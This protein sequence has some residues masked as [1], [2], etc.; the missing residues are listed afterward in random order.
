MTHRTLAASACCGLIAIGLAAS[1]ACSSRVSR[2]LEYGVGTS[3]DVIVAAVGPP[4]RVQQ[5]TDALRSLCPGGAT[6]IAV[7]QRR[8]LVPWLDEGAVAVLCVDAS[9]R[10]IAT[11]SSSPW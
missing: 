9:D 3:L 8:P 2:V 6:R 7:Y 1:V 11:P 10:V 4:D 5:N